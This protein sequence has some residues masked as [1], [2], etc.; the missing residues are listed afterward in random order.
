MDV[1]KRYLHN[2]ALTS[3]QLDLVKAT[4]RLGHSLVSAIPRLEGVANIIAQQEWPLKDAPLIGSRVLKVVG[5]FQRMRFGQSPLN[6]L[7]MM[8]GR[9]EYDSNAL[10][11]LSDVVQATF[12]QSEVT[13]SQLSEGM[14]LEDDVV[15]LSGRIL[16]AKGSEM[17]ETIIQKLSTLRRSVCGVKEPIQV[18]LYIQATSQRPN[19]SL[20]S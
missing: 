1:M 15:D 6:A 2:Q 13:V 11:R 7:R 14:V 20:A 4:P 12:Q 5:D 17:H 18:R 16:I 8:Q 9:I 19:Q 3:E 10:A